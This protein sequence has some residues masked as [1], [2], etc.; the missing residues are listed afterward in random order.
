MTGNVKRST[1]TAVIT[2][3]ASSLLYYSFCRHKLAT[4][5]FKFQQIQHN[6]QEYVAKKGTLQHEEEE[7]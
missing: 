3:S 5:K 2:L 6:L 1:N 7:D 4:E